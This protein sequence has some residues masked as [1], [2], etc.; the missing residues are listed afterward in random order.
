M[1]ERS[2]VCLD[3]ALDLLVLPLSY[4][5]LNVAALLVLA[6]LADWWNPALSDWVWVSCA[7]AGALMLY[8]LRGWSLSG[9]GFRGL[10]DLIGA[11]IFIGWKLVLMLGRDQPAE[12]VR[13]E[14]KRT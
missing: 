4:V 3:L 10:L 8:I 5:A 12:W 7:C 13:T 11:P 6:L 1:R 14:R 2:A 9:T